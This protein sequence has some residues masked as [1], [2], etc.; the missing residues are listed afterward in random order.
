MLILISVEDMCP[1]A[2][3]EWAMWAQQLLESIF[4]LEIQSWRVS[5]R[6]TGGV[7][8]LLKLAC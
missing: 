8:E 5:R 4:N 6:F 2:S 7:C 1:H 3:K